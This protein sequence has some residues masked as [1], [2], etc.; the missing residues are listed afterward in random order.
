MAERS[1]FTTGKVLISLVSVTTAIGP[2]AAD[3]NE[4]HIHNPTWPPHAK[5]HN[6]QTMSLG[7]ALA[8]TGLWQLWKS[9]GDQR[10]ALDAA[11]VASS[12]YW[13]TQISALFYP[14][15]KAV[16]PPA[17]ATFPQGKFA[18]PSLGLLGLGYLLERRRI[19]SADGRVHG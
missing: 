7:A 4:T 8:A 15:A 13:V 16:D 2:Y 10:E 3:W 11:A 9:R 17:T 18:L 14:G 12:L 1:R 19:A 5:F 6:G